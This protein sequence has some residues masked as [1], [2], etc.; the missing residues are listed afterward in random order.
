VEEKPLKFIHAPVQRGSRT[1]IES[2]CTQCL[3]HKL[4]SHANGT[5]EKWEADHICQEPARPKG[6]VTPIQR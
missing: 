1:L 2:T 3:A 5:L 4:V 6:K